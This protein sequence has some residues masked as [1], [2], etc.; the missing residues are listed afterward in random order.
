MK[1]YV[2]AET[3]NKS[4][5]EHNNINTIISICFVNTTTSNINIYYN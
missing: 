3:G 2:A 5:H 4:I 1:E